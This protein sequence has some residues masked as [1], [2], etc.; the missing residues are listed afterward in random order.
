MR[1]RCPTCGRTN[2][3]STPQNARYW[4]LLTLISEKLKVDGNT[5]EPTVWHEWFKRRFLGAKEFRLPGGGTIVIPNSSS[6]L[7]EDVFS[8]Y[9]TK[10]E[11]WALE[12]NV[13]LPDREGT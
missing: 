8:D 5:F 10:V 2:Q 6:E 11:V 13:F 4:A 3:R 1:V 12:R 9:L 7:D